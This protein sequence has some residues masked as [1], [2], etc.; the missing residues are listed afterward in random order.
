MATTQNPSLQWFSIVAYDSGEVALF[1]GDRS[2]E[3]EQEPVDFVVDIDQS[4][5]SLGGRSG[6]NS[7][8]VFFN[9][10]ER[11]GAF[12]GELRSSAEVSFFTVIGD[13]IATFSLA[14][15]EHAFDVL[16]ECS[17]TIARPSADSIPTVGESL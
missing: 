14:G 9:G 4:R 13:P 3:L 2:W 6:G 1:V 15:A 8:S 5:W 11:S 10:S 7:V 17:L 12:L 16:V